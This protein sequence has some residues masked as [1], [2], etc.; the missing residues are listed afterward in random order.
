[1]MVVEVKWIDKIKPFLF[2]AI[3]IPTN[4]LNNWKIEQFSSIPKNEITISSRGLLIKV[5]N[6]AGPL[7]FPFKSKSKISGFKIVGEFMGLPKFM[8]P[9]LQG[10][11][12]FD[13]YPLR[14]GFV[15][16]G[17]RKLSGIKK[18]FAAQWVKHLY[19]QVPDEAGLD[20]VRFFNVT[21]N[22]KQL[23]QERTHPN[24]DLLYEYFFVEVKS[25]GLF[26]YEFKFK[27]PIEVVAVWISIDG[28][29]TKSKF[30]VLI[31][32]IELQLPLP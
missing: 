22:S 15:V 23:D 2:A 3:V 29:D 27:Q 14:V 6:S 17:K 21:Q 1:M 19:E 30:E 8:N 24:S 20:S 12:G 11:K 18:M 10:E 4:N 16:P 7:I 13:D 28:D 25:V 26:T 31:S 9:L 32:S 5:H